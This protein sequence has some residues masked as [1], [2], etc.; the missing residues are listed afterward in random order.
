MEIALGRA[1]LPATAF[2]VLSGGKP[3]PTSEE[4][5]GRTDVGFFVCDGEEEAP[6]LWTQVRTEFSDAVIAHGFAPAEPKRWRYA[7]GYRGKTT[8]FVDEDHQ[9]AAEAHV[10]IEALTSFGQLQP[11]ERVANEDQ[12]T[13][14]YFGVVICPDA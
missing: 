14:W 9:E 11:V 4:L 8:V 13:R 3:Q 1:P 7:I 10:L 12:L 2:E 6:D 5:A